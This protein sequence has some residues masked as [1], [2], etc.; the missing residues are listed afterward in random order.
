MKNLNWKAIAEKRAEIIIHL[1]DHCLLSSAKQEEKWKIKNDKLETELAVLI[2]QE[3][4]EITDE[5]IE[6]YAKSFP[7]NTGNII[8]DAGVTAGFIE[9][10][11][12]VRDGLIK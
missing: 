8:I 2:S 10:A 6:K 11:K 1:N 5:M 3:V 12:A 4:E 9:G 7:G